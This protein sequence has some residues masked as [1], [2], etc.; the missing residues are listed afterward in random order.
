MNLLAGITIFAASFLLFAL[1]PLNAKRILPWFGGTSAVWSVC[2]VFYQ[3]AL[4]AGYLYAR[5]ITRFLKPKQQVVIHITLILL[6]LTLLPIGPS[7]RWKPTVNGHPSLLILEMLTAT[8]GLPFAVLSATSPLLQYWLAR[9]GD[10]LPYRLFAW[11]NFAS[12]SALLAYPLLIEPYLDA[13][14][15]STYWSAGFVL[16]AASCIVYALRTRKLPTSADLNR[17]ESLDTPRLSN[18]HRLY[19]LA[20][21]ACGS[22]LLLS[23]TN[24]IDENVAAVPLFWILP[25]AVY[26]VSFIFAFAPRNLYRRSLWLRLLAFALAMMAYAEYNTS[27]VLP[28]QISVPVF[29]A[30]LFI[31]CVFCHSELYLLRPVETNLTEFYLFV[32]TGGALGAVLIGLV[33]PQIFGGIY[34]FPLTMSLTGALALVLTWQTGSWSLRLL[35]SGVTASMLVVVVLIYNSYHFN[36]VALRRSFYG[37]LRVLQSPNND[38]DQ[39]RSLFHGTVRHGDQFMRTSRRLQAT[40]YYGPSSGIGILLREW[41]TLPKRV[42][43]VGLGSGT[44]AAYGF[45]GDNF[46]FYEINPQV[47]QLAQRSFYY[48]KDTRAHVDIV[49][50]DA[51]LSIEHEHVPLFDIIVLDAFSGDA[52]PVH[53]LTKQAMQLYLN[54]LAPGGVLAFHVSNN[55][56]ELAP[57]VLMLAD[58]AGFRCF[59]VKDTDDEENRVLASEWILVTNNNRILQNA[60]L[61]G[62]TTA[63]SDRKLRLWTDDYNSLLPILKTPEIRPR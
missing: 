49:E 60:D 17:T 51:R 43:V 7:L 23:I 13:Q 27:S 32:A 39:V 57:V 9:S 12:L 4:L 42:A 36:T 6:A 54:H 1:E 26:L 21:S 18:T 33:A 47:I 28:L 35:W 31:A 61:T 34:E 48:L 40:T 41:Q 55:F 2:L 58:N 14:Q 62:H 20:L 19:W 15:Q 53:L 24:H 16:F 30:G 8:I 52:I 37:S 22:M 5:L 44:L 50:G 29:L 10:R 25:V 56:L 45:A 63:I 59:D 38:L 46:R 11:S 3:L